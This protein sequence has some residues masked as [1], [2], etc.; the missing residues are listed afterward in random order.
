MAIQLVVISALLVITAALTY[1]SAMQQTR[2]NQEYILNIYSR[3]M[4]N[5]LEKMNHQLATVINEDYDITWLRNPDDAER[6]YASLRLQELLQTMMTV[7]QSAD[8]I[9]VASPEYDVCIDAVAQ[10]FSGQDKSLLR[11][12]FADYAENDD[13]RRGWYLIS[14]YGKSYLC[15]SAKQDRHAVAVIVSC[16]SLLREMETLRT[17]DSLRF[18]LTDKEGMLLAST[19]TAA[20][21]KA[22]ADTSAD[23]DTVNVPGSG[24]YRSASGER[25]LAS[26]VP[27]MDSMLILTC[28]EDIRDVTGNL[29]R[30]LVLVIIII[31]LLLA[32]SF[33]FVRKE[34]EM[35][36]QPMQRML[37][38]MKRVG[39]GDYALRMEDEKSEEFSLLTGTFN[40]LMDEI[41]NLKMQYYEK[42]IALS[43][44]EQKYIRL[45]IRPHFF[46]NAL[47]TINSLSANGKGKEIE[48]YIRALSKNIR[49]MFSS[50]LHTVAL[51]EE[52][53]H[54]ENYFEMQHLRYPDCLFYYIDI[55]EEVK[56]WKIPQMLIHTLIENEYK[57]AV[58]K[59]VPLMV[60]IRAAKE[61]VDGEDMLLLEVEDDGKG[62]PE[63]VISYINDDN[64]KR[65]DDGSRVG[66]WSVRR[67]MELMY[68][69]KGL[70][71][72]SNVSPHGALN[73][74]LVP[75]QPV[76]ERGKEYLEEKGIA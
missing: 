44:A 53:R 12:Y 7:D 49:Y 29:Y 6:L 20:A 74:I 50:G 26:S 76:N 14:L 59:D 5:R 57:Y 31:M 60:L 16:N 2:T 41:V 42:R 22:P 27:V 55:A 3:Q 70:L 1:H 47:T 62:Y 75:A 32:V 52:I 54:V 28:E 40:S 18:C 67:L 24:V 23:D 69:R 11:E 64:G 51:E 45:Q 61:Q 48:T 33:L 63:E 9:V 13:V 21:A 30:G 71:Q 17:Q 43:D 38:G 58:S 73:R 68:D 39:E 8:M 15:K 72:I 35:I 25:V 19:G 10:N 36:Y 37:G 34:R 56:D 65:E 4:E 46:L 66:L